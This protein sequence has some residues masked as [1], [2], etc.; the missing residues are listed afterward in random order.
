[1]RFVS[2]S[3]S[4]PSAPGGGAPRKTR[5]P[6]T[7]WLVT[8]RWPRR[9]FLVI[10]LFVAIAVGG[11]QVSMF[12][13]ARKTQAILHG[14]KQ[15]RIDATSEDQ[16]TQLVPYLTKYDWVRDG[17][18]HRGYEAKISNDQPPPYK[19]PWQAELLYW[20]ERET[21][22]HQIGN[23]IGYTPFDFELWID[24]RD[25]KVS[26]IAYSVDA[27][28]GWPR[29]AGHTGIVAVRSVHSS[30]ARDPWRLGINSIEDFS[31]QYDAESWPRMIRATYTSDAPANV[32]E[33][34]FDLDLVCMWKLFNRCEAP[35]QIAPKIDEDAKSIA[36]LA[37]QQI[38]S[39]KCPDSIVAGR[40]K[41][42]PDVTVTLLEVS[43]S[44]RVDVDED[45]VEK[46]NDWFTDYKFKEAIRGTSNGPWTNI[47]HRQAIGKPGD[48][49]E[50]M[51]SQIYPETKIGTEV[52]YFSGASFE[53]C[54]F[55]PATPSNLEIVRT[56][57]LAPK[58][59]EDEPVPP[60]M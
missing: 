39:G 2:T 58:L 29:L 33:R 19:L 10:F 49:M 53:T 25:G 8:N 30:W 21:G 55:I 52:L 43:G 46:T 36:A 50:T 40:M 9:I 5:F 48:W 12:W 44:R 1:M 20:I 23:W 15:V 7:R 6:A 16:L 59:A 51:G 34:L 38:E 27:S 31:P 13:M 56:A 24:I 54:K 17:A 35:Q 11:S 42:L 4:I 3:N 28:G 60:P 32:T 45:A 37:R 57:P 22:H 26:K 14:L 47:R 41:Y 18:A